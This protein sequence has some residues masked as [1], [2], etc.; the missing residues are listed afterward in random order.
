M[1]A[2][3]L[4]KELREKKIEQLYKDVASSYKDLR[5]A[6]FKIANLESKDIHLKRNL[7]KKIARLWTVIQEKELEKIVSSTN[8]NQVK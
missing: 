1:K 2:Q 6:R 5:E 4:I 7:K 8:T 3:E